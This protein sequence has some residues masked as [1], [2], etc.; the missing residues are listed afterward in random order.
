MT[1]MLS[2]PLVSHDIDAN[3][4]LKYEIR[5]LRNENRVINTQL[6]LAYGHLADVEIQLEHY[7]A[8]AL[9]YRWL[10][11]QNLN[12]YEKLHQSAEELDATIDASIEKENNNGNTE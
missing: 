9:R 4:D 3:T 5:K 1:D 10:R 8:D 7:K 11:Q 6:S 12:D 2:I